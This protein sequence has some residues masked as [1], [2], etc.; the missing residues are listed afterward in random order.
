MNQIILDEKSL[1]R[2]FKM[3]IYN[4]FIRY[5]FSF[6]E[7][8]DCQLLGRELIDEKNGNID[9]TQKGK[10]FIENLPPSIILSKVRTQ[11]ISIIGYINIL[12]LENLTKLITKALNQIPIA[13][14][15]TYLA[16]E[17]LAKYSKEVYDQKVSETI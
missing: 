16:D 2:L 6:D 15:P 9:I 12:P 4:E 1:D 11:L 8:Y 13:E 3:Y 17:Y 14:F 10:K 7:G 5:N